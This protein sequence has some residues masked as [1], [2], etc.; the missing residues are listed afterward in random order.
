MFWRKKRERKTKEEFYES[1]LKEMSDENEAAEEEKKKILAVIAYLTDGLLIFDKNNNISLIN[2]QAEK[3]FNVESREVLGRSVLELSHF[4]NI[5]PLISFLGG[6]IRE[7]SK[8]EIIIKEN[9]ILE[10]SSV[11]MIVKKEKIG[12]LV[13][14]HDISK[15]KLIERM[16]SE[17]VTLAAHQLRTPASA[18]KWTIRMLLDGE[19]GEMTKE[20]K[21]AVEKTY[22]TNEKMIRLVDDLLNVAQ[23]E[24]GK[25]L[26]RLVLSDIEEV[27]QSVINFYG[28]RIKQKNLK[29]KFQKSKEKL[30]QVMLDEEKMIIAVKDILDNAIRYTPVGGRITISI[31]MR[32]EEIE[33]QIQ[34]TGLGIPRNQQNQ[35]FTKFFRAANI[36]KIDTEGTGLGLYISKNI[37]EAHGGRIWFK[38]EKGKGSIFYFT[39][40]VKEKFGEFL[41]K[42]FY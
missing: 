9:F 16:K 25:Y 6:G 17:F 42:E 4:P 40:P 22:K 27:I 21:E 12:S 32:I 7:V 30:P 23:I 3:I 36:K 18:V 19:M 28:E 33:I 13:I 34:D 1:F 37:I 15:E 10:V 8:K 29:F 20:Q 35:V 38:S 14:L 31:R 24:E 41:T 2:P 39:I 11:S 5:Q 26:S